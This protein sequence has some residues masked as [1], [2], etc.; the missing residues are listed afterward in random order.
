MKK[1]LVKASKACRNRSSEGIIDFIP[2]LL[3]SKTKMQKEGERRK[4]KKE[5]KT[6]RRD[7]KEILQKVCDSVLFEGKDGVVSFCMV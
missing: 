1:S 7:K 3:V 6:K 2:Y 5:A 4:K